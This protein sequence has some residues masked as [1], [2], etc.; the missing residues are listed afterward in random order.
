MKKYQERLDNFM[1]GLRGEKMDYVPIMI[2]FEPKYICQYT[3]G[4]N[5]EVSWNYDDLIPRYDQVLQDFDMDITTGIFFLPPQRSAS[6]GSRLWVQNR[7][8]GYMQHPEISAMEADEYEMLIEDPMYCIVSKILPRMY[9][10]FGREAPYNS[11][12]FARALLYTKKQFENFYSKIYETTMEHELLLYYNTMFYC[13][14]DLLADHL[15][16]ITQI[17]LDIHRKGFLIEKACDV[18]L[19]LMTEY[20]ESTNLAGTDGFPVACTWSHLPPMLRPKQF[21]RY[22]WPTFK[23]ICE[24]L[25]QKG[26]TL[27]INFQ[28]DYS[29]GLYYDY[30]RELP[31]NS[32]LIAVEQQDFKQTVKTLGEHNMVSCSY[33]LHYLSDLTTRECIEKAKELMDIG[34]EKGRFYFGLDRSAQDFRDADPDKLKEVLAFVRAYGHY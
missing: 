20:V 21:E 6:L 19:D 25:T 30:Y 27:Y 5:L 8:N 22:Y 14:F 9:T 18:L 24:R 7:H 10:E 1:R 12:A 4:D 33:P 28:G 31:E 11:L 3:G 15:R 29:K 16:G 34:M 26:I 13:P 17:S 23:K 2:D 32:L